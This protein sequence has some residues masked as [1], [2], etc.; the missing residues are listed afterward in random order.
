MEDFWKFLWLNVAKL[1]SFEAPVKT[2]TVLTLRIFPSFSGLASMAQR[3][4]SETEA[5]IE[6]VQMVA[7]NV[8]PSD[9]LTGRCEY[10]YDMALVIL[11][12]EPLEMRRSKLCNKFAKKDIKI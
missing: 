6:R 10:T 9:C 12:I 5:D 8:I 2:I 7:V 4:Y 1:S 3:T 11:E